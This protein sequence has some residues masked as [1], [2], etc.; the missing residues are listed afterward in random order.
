MR[1][2]AI[3]EQFE[4]N[5]LEYLKIRNIAEEKVHSTLSDSKVLLKYA[6]LSFV[7][8]MKKDPDKYCSLIYN[9]IY[10]PMSST[11]TY[12]SQYHASC[13]MD[14]QALLYPEQDYF[15]DG[16]LNMVVEEAQKVYNNLAKERID[17][18]IADYARST[19]SS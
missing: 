15:S 9:D 3:V 17:A 11:T 2:E 8:S 14:G 5:N 6:F 19:A 1:L 10:S 18:S 4:N 13:N 7:E 12:L 16:C